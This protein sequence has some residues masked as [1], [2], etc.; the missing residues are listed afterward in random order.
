MDCNSL[1]QYFTEGAQNRSFQITLVSDGSGKDKFM[2]FA[3]SIQDDSNVTLAECA[4]PAFGFQQ[5]LFC[6]EAYGML[7][8]VRFIHHLFVFTDSQV[9]WD[10]ES[11]A[12]NTG[13]IPRVCSQLTY[14]KEY[15]S[16]TL[17]SEWDL[18]KQITKTVKAMQCLPTFSH[19]K[20]HQDRDIPYKDL[21][22]HSQQNI[23]AGRLAREY[24]DRY[25]TYLATVPCIEANKVQ[26]K[27]KAKMTHRYNP[28]SST[29]CPLCQNAE[30]DMHHSFQ[31]SAVDMIKWCRKLFS[32][33][34]ELHKRI[35]THPALQDVLDYGLRT[36]FGVEDRPMDS[37]D[38]NTETHQLCSQQALLGRE[39]LF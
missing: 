21:K 39:Q 15:P 34:N 11:Y 29:L 31:C 10:I 22:G 23:D 25:G 13:L 30:E 9:H 32:K 27:V 12:D 38:W 6:A 5:S 36:G 18:V 28:L 33:V 8:S 17:D 4:G 19:V 14:D 7:S 20:G 37:Y 1:I 3:W 26:I 35:H 2:T 16:N 24:M